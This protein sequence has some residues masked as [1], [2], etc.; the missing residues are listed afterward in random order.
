[1]TNDDWQPE[2]LVRDQEMDPD[3]SLTISWEKGQRPS[4]QEVARYSSTVKA[5]WYQWDSL[6]LRDGLLKRVIKSLDGVEDRL[7]LV[8]PGS[9]RVEVMKEVH[10]G[11]T[12]GHMGVARTVA[13]LRERYYWVNCQA[14]VKDWCKKCA[15]CVLP[16]MAPRNNRERPCVKLMLAVHSSK[17]PST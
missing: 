15:T 6:V 10:D 7:Q 16:V 5:F 4:W 12:G 13:K 3:L 1:M 8:I 14:D 2:E 11:V 17:L 9:R